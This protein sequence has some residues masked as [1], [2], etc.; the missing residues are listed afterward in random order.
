MKEIQCAQLKDPVTVTDRHAPGQSG[1]LAKQ[2]GP[3]T[4]CE[5]I[6]F[7]D[8]LNRCTFAEVWLAQIGD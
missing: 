4:A 7:F 5:P 8:D 2:H 3:L 1:F 6:G